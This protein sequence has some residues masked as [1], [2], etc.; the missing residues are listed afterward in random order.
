MKHTS[1]CLACALAF[2]ALPAALASR[3]SLSGLSSKGSSSEES[4]GSQLLTAVLSNDIAQVRC[5]A[6]PRALPPWPTH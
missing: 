6:A 2:S 4:L 3:P 5:G 1:L